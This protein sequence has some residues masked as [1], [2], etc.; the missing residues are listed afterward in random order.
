[1]N[2]LLQHT[3]RL[4]GELGVRPN[5]RLGQHFLVDSQVVQDMLTASGVDARDSVLEIG[6]GLGTLTEALLRRAGRLSAVE[7]DARL[8]AGLRDRFAHERKLRILSADFL[9]LDV[10]ETFPDAP[11][12]VVASLPYNAA[13][14]I[15]FRL[16]EHR[17]RFPET[18][19][20]LQHEVAE[21][22][23][24]GPGT[25][26]YGVISV[27]IQLFATTQSIRRVAPHSFFPVPQVESRIVRTIFRDEPRVAVVDHDLFR[28]IVKAAF[29]QRRKTLRNALRVLGAA[30]LPAVG[31]QADVDLQ[32]RG[33]TLALEEFAR[34]ANSWARSAHR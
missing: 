20:M 31:R 7:S 14:Q 12:K 27:L 29:N 24:A 21:R 1:M 11:A 28:R 18:T 5:K 3:R 32:R 34:L 6:P 22:L 26:A 30:D 13:T 16:L 33:E 23:T 25:K 4:L 2:N 10:H 17:V 19:L 15:L 9:R 8:A